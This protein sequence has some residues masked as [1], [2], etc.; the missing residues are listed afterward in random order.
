MRGNIFKK[1][2]A[3]LMISTLTMATLGAAPVAKI[4][5][6]TIEEKPAFT[7][8][9]AE[10]FQK[11]MY[12]YDANWCGD[13]GENSRLTWRGDC[14]MEDSK[15]PLK[16]MG[17]GLVGTNMSDA[18]IKENMDALDPDGDG[19]VNLVGGFHDAGDH[20]KFG[21]PQSY[22]G[23][24]LGWGYYE[25]PDAYEGIGD[26]D[27]I[28]A[29]LRQ[30]NDYFLRC[31]FRDKKGD[32]VAFAYQVG[33][34]T[35]DHCYWGP[36]E[37]QTTPRPAW[38]ATKETP[39][40]DQCAGAAASLTINYLNFKEKDPEYAEKCLD[41]AIALYDFAKANRGIGFSG[42]FYNSSY[43]DDELSWAAVWLKIA[44]G[45]DKYINDIVSKD[46]SGKY[47]GY[48]KKIINS[49]SDTWQNIWVHS[50]DT[51]WGGVFAKLAPVTNDPVH[52]YYFRWNIEYWSGVPHENKADQ[53]FLKPTPDGFRVVANWGSA[54][55]NTA[56]Q[57]C[58][59]VYNKYKPN[60]TFVDWCKDQT[61]YILGDNP[62]N[63]AYEVGYDENSA[64]H[65][66]HRASHG[67]LT[68]S[69][70]FPVEQRH[71]LWGALV[72]G[73]DEEDNH[74]DL[75]TDFVYNEVAIDYNA[76][77]VG[78][79]A[80]L[81]QLY[82]QGQEPVKNFPP[83]DLDPKPFYASAKLEQENKERTQITVA[84]HN[85]T[86]TPPSNENGLKARYFFNISEMLEKGQTADDL[87][88]Q[89][90]YDQALI[91]DGKG[92]NISKPQPWDEESGVYYIDLSWEGN[93]FHGS[94]EVH[95]A[96]VPAMDSSWKTNWDPTNDFSRQGIE[97][98]DAET[99]Y[100]P[101][102]NKGELVYG[103]EPEK[104]AVVENFTAKISAPADNTI[105]KVYEGEDSVTVSA[106]VSGKVEGISKVDFY[107]NGKLIGTDLSAPYS[108][109]FEPM[110]SA[111]EV[112]SVSYEITAVVTS[113]SGKTAKSEPI[114]VK[115]IFKAPQKSVI[116]FVDFEK[117]VILDTTNGETSY[118]VKV[119]KV[120]PLEGKT[121]ESIQIFA[122]GKLIG[123]ADGESCEGIY[124]APT[125]FAPKKDTLIPVVFTASAVLSDGSEMECGPVTLYVKLPVK[126]V[127]VTGLSF[128][129][130][131]QN[132]NASTNTIQQKLILK[133]TGSSDLELSK[134]SVRYYYK[135]DN[136]STQTMVSD[137]AGLT[138][139]KS[140]YYMDMTKDIKG[141]FVA[142]DEPAADADTYCEF[143][144][145]EGTLGSNN[146]LECDVRIVNSDWS[147]FDQSND[148]SFKD[149]QNIVVLYDGVVIS[150]VEPN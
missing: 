72:G 147:F 141:T 145:G 66:H 81:Y 134:I 115:A 112:D 36:P 114:T 29:I 20:V 45:E 137:H 101:V 144:F 17:D 90:M 32:V 80:A 86:S 100:I 21:L 11:S 6:E 16:N 22:A 143:T 53:T 61:D 26:T 50:W 44:T 10:A 14:H 132:T 38:F 91:I 46:A 124:K 43:D 105:V 140:P 119:E 71:V 75:T 149:D 15:V 104:G 62:M 142:M 136:G 97:K 138:L 150:G 1:G 98:E 51:V 65:P 130:V 60:Q 96:L 117:D 12:F 113:T 28:E 30:F 118:Q 108:V 57:L 55:Y 24:T 94:R 76:A 3:G 4:N 106:N 73:P 7:A 131:N 42:G 103:E 139:N 9:Y 133:N 41:T 85:D 64:K 84:I 111:A 56:A 47:T 116:D 68:N 88:V 83:K 18:F 78:A 120:A 148:Y 102:Y 107:A 125:G 77:F 49:T 109:E 19:Y 69:M 13:A 99:A 122:D 129:A 146:Q 82:G 23:A 31:T 93:S 123:E 52:W 95:F 5:A 48:L 89:V 37:L 110:Q 87:S 126:E 54:R 79:L 59:L 27:H 34:G 39:A 128:Q 67:S 8:N 121:I 74:V 70:E 58:A 40:S 63:R 135:K 127:S 92:V 2:I 33:E 35:S 25:F